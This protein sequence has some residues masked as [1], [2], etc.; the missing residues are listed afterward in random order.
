[1]RGR[2]VVGRDATDTNSEYSKAGTKGGARSVQLTENQIPRHSHG[3]SLNTNTQGQHSHPYVDVLFPVEESITE[4]PNLGNGDHRV[5]VSHTGKK[6]RYVPRGATTSGS[7]DHMH[8]VSGR[9][10]STGANTAF[11]NRPPFYTVVYIVYKGTDVSPL[12]GW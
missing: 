6:S 1:M 12:V 2:F 8:S 11:D 7:G 3:V 9:T 4:W 5:S 10:E